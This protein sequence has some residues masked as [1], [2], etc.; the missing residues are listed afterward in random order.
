MFCWC[1]CYIAQ[2]FVLCTTPSSWGH[3]CGWTIISAT[4]NQFDNKHNNNI[5]ALCTTNVASTAFHHFSNFQFRYLDE[6]EAGMA[7]AYSFRISHHTQACLSTIWSG[8]L[9]ALEIACQSIDSNRWKNEI[10][11]HENIFCDFES[12]QFYRNECQLYSCSCVGRHYN[13]THTRIRIAPPFGWHSI[14]LWLDTLRHRFNNYNE[15]EIRSIFLLVVERE[16]DR[17]VFLACYCT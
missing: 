8:V 17:R 12:T 3:V 2:Y 15:I 9:F 10:K 11:F 14:R 7:M 13:V 1:W 4:D 6:E 16:R 5:D